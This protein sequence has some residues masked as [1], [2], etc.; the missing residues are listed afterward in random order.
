MMYLK[1][2][3]GK[4]YYR[5]LENSWIEIDKIGKEDLMSLLDKLLNSEFEME[6]Y[7]SDLLANKAHQV[8]YRNLYQ[9][10]SELLKNKRRF[11]DE[12]E[13]LYKTAFEKY[14]NYLPSEEK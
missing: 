3:D 10:F 14:K 12:S 9:N 6:E 11:K 4:G 5:L 13:K 7:K 1:I 2:D 8:I